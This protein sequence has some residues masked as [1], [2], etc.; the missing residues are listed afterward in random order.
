MIRKKNSTDS[1]KSWISQQAAA[2]KDALRITLCCFLNVIANLCYIVT[3]FGPIN[4]FIT[5]TMDSPVLYGFYFSLWDLMPFLTEEF[6]LLA[7]CKEFRQNVW[8][9]CGTIWMW[10]HCRTPPRPAPRND[11]HRIAIENPRRI[12][13][14]VRVNNFVGR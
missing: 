13:A 10:M 6:C 12:G 7:L 4:E 9:Q 8:A 3:R 5:N 1:T 11:V 2:E 14:A